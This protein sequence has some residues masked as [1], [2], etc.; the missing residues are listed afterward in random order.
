MKSKLRTL[1]EAELYRRTALMVEVRRIGLSEHVL[2]EKTTPAQLVRNLIQKAEDAG[3]EGDEKASEKF[4]QQAQDLAKQNKLDLA[5]VKA[6]LKPRLDKSEPEIEPDTEDGAGEDPK[7]VSNDEP[8]KD[9]SKPKV[10][11]PGDEKT[12][13]KDAEPTAKELTPASGGDS[14]DKPENDDEDEEDDDSKSNYYMGSRGDEDD[15]EPEEGAGTGNEEGDNAIEA[16]QV[17]YNVNGKNVGEK[18]IT[19]IPA[20]W[21][22]GWLERKKYPVSSLK[23]KLEATKNAARK[24]QPPKSSDRTV[25]DN[26][27][28]RQTG[29]QNKIK[30]ITNVLRDFEKKHNK[31]IASHNDSIDRRKEHINNIVDTLSGGNPLLKTIVGLMA[32]KLMKS[33]EKVNYT[34]D[35]RTDDW[36]D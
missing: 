2:T 24:L 27:R 25:L 34:G 35:N 11:P 16:G 5:K 4:L 23:D 19:P 8:E 13:P 32:D 7:P 15:D 26:F 22:E 6:K 9:E 14:E 10:A 30:A 3:D 28:A 36:E 29:Y 18:T 31:D 12:T 20:Q 17:T 21:F 1:I 33:K